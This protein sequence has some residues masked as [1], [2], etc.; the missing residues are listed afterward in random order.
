MLKREGSKN[1]TKLNLSKN[2]KLTDKAGLFLGDAL[3]DNPH[4]PV[5]KLNFKKIKL[6]EDGLHRIIEAANVNKH[7][8]NL[9]LGIVTDRGLSNMAH[10]MVYNTTLEKLKFAECPTQPW[11]EQTKQNFIKMLKQN[12]TLVK[13]KFESADDSDNKD[14]K[15]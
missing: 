7:I 6:S 2:Y 1:I 15:K 10:C 4:H 9:N 3:I 11:Q 12:K 5:K 8:V 13:V 14:F